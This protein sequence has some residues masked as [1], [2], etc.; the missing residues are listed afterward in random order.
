VS[1]LSLPVGV[2]AVIEFADPSE[3]R[4]AFTNL[5]YTRFH[6]APL[7]LEWAPEDTFTTSYSERPL[8]PMASAKTPR[9]ETVKVGGGGAPD[10]EPEPDTTLFVKN[11]NFNTTEEGL[12]AHFVSAGAIFSVSIATKK[13]PRTGKRLSMGFGFV[14]FWHR[15]GVDAAL[16]LLQHS[17]LDTHSLE[18]KRAN[19]AAEWDK[20]DVVK[21]RFAGVAADG[22]GKPSTKMLVRN[23]PF[24]ATRQEV[25]E[26]FKTFGELTAVRLPSK[27]SGTGSHRGFAFVEFATKG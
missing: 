2:T 22:G 9:T 27:V 16:K 13:D 10:A 5:A 15:S 7:Y 8:K 20:S 26:I 19:R 3:A 11:L 17:Q 4:A 6:S 25:T 14:T 21:E 24:Q 23:I 12:K 18:L 1:I